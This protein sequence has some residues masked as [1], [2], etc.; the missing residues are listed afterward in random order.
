MTPNKALTQALPSSETITRVALP[1]GITVY[2]YAN[3]STRSVVVSGGLDGGGALHDPAA[4]S[5]LAV[6]TAGMVMR[7]TQNHDFQGL[8][9]SLEDIGA[10]FGV[11]AGVH[12]VSFGG[13]ALAEDLPTLLDVM[14]EVLRRPTFPAEH[15]EL[16]RGEVMTWL[17]YGLQDTRR[18]AA[19]AFRQ[20]L[21]PEAHPYY[22]GS[23]G[24]L[25]TVPTLTADMLREFHAQHYGAKGMT[26]VI[27]GNIDPAQVADLVQARL[28]DWD[29]PRQPEWSAVAPVEMGQG[30]RRA[31]V[32][33]AGKTQSDVVLGVVGPS[34]KADDFQAAR[35]ANSILG[36]F[37]MMGRVGENVRVKNGMAYYASSRLEG[38][39]GP[40]AWAIS[41]GVNPVNVERA[42]ELSVQEVRQMAETLVTDE[43]IEDNRSYFTGR[44]PL[45]LESNEG[46]AGTIAS[47]VE[48]DLG[49][50]YLTELPGIIAG[51]TR[52]D[53]MESV[54]RYWQPDSYVVSVS[55]P[56]QG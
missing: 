30:V 5:G 44:L 13:K 48:F 45:Q 56:P 47:M 6:M 10:D 16:L 4:H 23:R 55:G 11:S 17:K 24:T 9:A 7:G 32:P 21:Y 18:Q 38:G 39:H 22:R 27:V 14:A 35:M 1:N 43:E 50:D 49:L 42:I 19:Q 52:E 26:V 15:L 12:G 25:E 53:V 33:I 51:L 28:G 46:V 2:A 20:T 29:N 54:R 40:G 37:G 3:P 8:A 41:A 34:R 31:F 36:E